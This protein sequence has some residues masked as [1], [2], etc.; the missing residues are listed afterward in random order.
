[1]EEVITMS[2]EEV[3]RHHIIR[4]VMERKL[5]QRKAA[6]I[7]DLGLRQIKRLCAQVRNE[8]AR[9]IVHG[10][11]GRPSNNHKDPE[12]LEQVLSAVHDPLWEDFGPTF[13]QEKL[14]QYHG[15]KLGKETL[16]QLMLR[17]GIWK[18]RRKGWRHRSWRARWPCIGMLVQL[19]GSVHDWFEGR[20]PKCVLLI[21]IDDATS[22]ILYGEFVK[23]EDTLTLMRSTWNYL[24]H[25][26][27]PLAFYVDKDSIYK[28]N[29]G[30]EGLLERLITQFT[31]AMGEL[32]IK[33]IFAN[34][35]Q[36]KG[37]VERG[38]GTHQD[39]LVK[40]LR[41]RGIN[42]MIDAN[43]YLWD[44]YIPEHNER[45]AVAP[46]RSGDAH[47]PLLAAHKL[48]EILS[49]R[50]ERTVYNDYTL[51]Y[52]PGFLQILE[53]QIVRVKPGDKVE[54]EERLDGT[55]HVRFKGEYLNFKQI[56]KR[57]YK[58][59]LVARPSQAKRYDDPRIKGVGSRP[60]P[61]HPWRRLFLHGP[62]KVGLPAA[63]VRG[64]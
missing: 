10:L 62:H 15:I 31:R 61:N 9:G 4:T 33:V 1:M 2:K 38:F 11:R 57:P 50:H 29:K 59:Y 63:S 42:N 12:L 32:A 52:S 13:A 41:L 17:S 55:R 54:V 30:S 28:V 26:G 36:A 19:D 43:R 24:K 27:R 37:R 46:A 20:G 40:E 22:K 53:H 18:L 3:N 14:E 16:R 64:L 56:P 44:E 47:R 51:S 45:F 23:V 25:C 49:L 48:E 34:S 5:P 8:G 39:R 35:P 7:L 58:P 60:G 6:A 21:Y